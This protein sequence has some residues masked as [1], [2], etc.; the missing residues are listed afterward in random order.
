VYRHLDGA[1]VVVERSLH[2]LPYPASGVGA[3]AVASIRVEIRYGLHQ[4]YITFLDKVS[5]GSP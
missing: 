1:F 5:N 4:A 3:E 2:R